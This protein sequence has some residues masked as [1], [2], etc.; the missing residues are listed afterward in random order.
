MKSFRNKVEQ[1]KS[2]NIVMEMDVAKY[3]QFLQYAPRKQHVL[4]NTTSH[5]VS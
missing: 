3:I 2:A 4:Q 5:F 1:Y